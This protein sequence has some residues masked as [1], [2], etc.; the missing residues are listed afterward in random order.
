VTPCSTVDRYQRFGGTCYFHVN[1]IIF[2][3]RLYIFTNRLLLI[4]IECSG[5]SSASVRSKGPTFRRPSLPPP[6]DDDDDD[7]DDD[8]GRE[9]LRNALRFSPN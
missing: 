1:P 8:G 4:K 9:E 3:V 6:P 5:L 2:F 7:D